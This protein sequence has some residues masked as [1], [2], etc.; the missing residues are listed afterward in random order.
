VALGS[1]IKSDNHNANL[2]L[3]LGGFGSP[4][5]QLLCALG[6]ADQEKAAMTFTH[7]S[8]VRCAFEAAGVTGSEIC[9]WPARK[10]LASSLFTSQPPRPKG[11]ASAVATLV[12]E[13]WNSCERLDLKTN[14]GSI[15][16]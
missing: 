12:A 13:R 2:H 9:A 7:T 3:E 5:E 15:R 4:S 6:R 10:P 16:L 1:R 11:D 14:F 8:A